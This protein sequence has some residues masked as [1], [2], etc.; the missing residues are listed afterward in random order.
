MKQI[1]P[2]QVQQ[3][4]EAGEP[5]NIIDVR[6]PS[7][8]AQGKIRGAVN[9]PLGLLE[10]KM[11]ELNKREEYIIVCQSGGRSSQATA[12]LEYQGFKVQNMAGGMN[13]WDGETE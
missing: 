12:F 8:V 10:F 2:D 6:Q 1:R 5:V 3:R 7:E 11:N 13:E 4:L 9:I